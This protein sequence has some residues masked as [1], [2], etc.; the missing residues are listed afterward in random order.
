M[1][2]RLLSIIAISVC[3][4][5]SCGNANLPIEGITNTNLVLE[6]TDEFKESFSMSATGE[7]KL[8]V[9]PVEFKNEKVFSNEDLSRINRAFFD[10]NLSLEKGN[11]YSVTEFYSRSSHNK[12]RITGEVTDVLKV[13]YTVK[14]ITDDGNY[15][16]G[17]PALYFMEQESYS[18]EFF[19][20]YDMDKDGFVDGVVFIYSTPKSDR[21]GSFWAWVATFATEQ[22][23]ERPTFSRHM[24][25][26]IDFLSTKSYN[27]DAHTLIHETGHMFCLRDYYPTDSMDLALGGHSM[28]DYNISDHDPYSKMLLSWVDPLYYDFNEV[29]K[30]E[31]TLSA[32]QDT[33]E[34]I[35]L[36]PSWNHSVMDE[37]LLLEYYTPTGLNELD[38]LYLYE[39]RPLGFTES[40]LKIYHVDSRITKCQYD[41]NTKKIN[42]EEYVDYIPETYDEDIYYVI[43]ASNSK[44]DS[45]TDTREGRYKQIALVDN[46]D[47]NRFQAGNAADNDSLFQEGDVFD[48][49]ESVFFIQ[50]QETG[51]SCWNNG[52]PINFRITVKKMTKTNVTLVI[53]YYGE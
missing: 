48:T 26:S 14:E 33:N 49:Q 21:E 23:V 2:K 7:Q 31:I 15:F 30:R 20:K 6:K 43:G 47:Y 32:F 53:E 4:L 10:E 1:N 16:P 27:V 12:L 11:Y 18:N 39:N 22:N 46:L 19:Q 29:K 17:V 52:S 42:F 3:V 8:L 37:Y 5:A 13:P 45:R 36:N 38:S 35:L 44:A 28:M 41:E 40:G 50:N 25:C 34:F 9:I 24:W 51:V